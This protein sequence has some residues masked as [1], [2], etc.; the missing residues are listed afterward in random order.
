VDLLLELLPGEGRVLSIGCGIGVH[1]A[2]LMES[3]LGLELVCSDIQGEMLRMVPSYLPSVQADMTC[4]PFPDGVF[5]AVYEVTALVF[6]SDPEKA[7]TEMARVLRPGGRL[8]LLTLNPLSKWGR[9]RLRELPAPWGELEGLVAMVDAATGGNVSVDHALNLEEDV[10]R[11][12]EGLED[13]AL[14]VLVSTKA[15]SKS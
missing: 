5:D 8:V 3:R 12:S 10:L 15:R 13:A 4:L 9:D 2:A 1:E 6:V 14:L 11:P 7:L